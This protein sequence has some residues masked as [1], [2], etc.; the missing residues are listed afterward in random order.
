MSYEYS[1]QLSVNLTLGSNFKLKWGRECGDRRV[2]Y[3]IPTGRITEIT[4]VSRRQPFYDWKIGP[5][6]LD[7][8]EAE[9]GTAEAVGCNESM[10]KRFCPETSNGSEI[11]TEL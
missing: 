5:K 2:L 1:H 8:W 10:L 11:S 7:Q 4:D 9:A 6:A 3:S